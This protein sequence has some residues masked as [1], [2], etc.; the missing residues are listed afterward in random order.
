MK[1]RPSFIVR[2]L[3]TT[4]TLALFAI[5]API[6]FADQEGIAP[7]YTATTPDGKHIFVVLDYRDTPYPASGMYRNDGSTVPLWTVDWR[8]FALVPSGGEHLVRLGKWADWT[9]SYNEEALTFFSNGQPVKT[10]TTAELIDLPWML[11]HSVS[12]YAWLTSGWSP[13]KHDGH[14]EVTV[15]F[16][17]YSNESVT[18]NERNQTV[19][20]LTILGDRLTFDLRTGEIVSA[21]H[22][23]TLPMIVMFATL[24]VG[25]AVFREIYRGTGSALQM[26]GPSNVLMGGLFTFSLTIIP[27][28]AV[29]FFYASYDP[30]INSYWIMVIV[31]FETLPRYIVAFF[32]F[33]QGDGIGRGSWLVICFWVGCVA[34]FTILDRVVVFIDKR[35][36]RPEIA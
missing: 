13:S 12:H 29:W 7:G 11:P 4:T 19:E 34:V 31:S 18:F 2:I 1:R 3:V 26:I 25:Y 5:I 14:A 8:A 36:R 33:L 21:K 22:P 6:A 15:D 27:A 9:G 30:E 10:Y 16:N 24:L 23:A 20:L 35:I 17:T 32:G 28:A